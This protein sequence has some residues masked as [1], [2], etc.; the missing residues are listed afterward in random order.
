M[1]GKI[2]A[3]PGE[4][5]RNSAE[6]IIARA[7]EL[8]PGVFGER[9]LRMYGDLFV[10]GSVLTPERLAFIQPEYGRFFPRSDIH[11]LIY[12]KE[13][14]D[15]PH[16]QTAH[17]VD[18]FLGPS[19]GGKDSILDIVKENHP[20]VRIRTTTTRPPRRDASQD[21]I[22]EARYE[23][24]TAEEFVELERGGGFSEVLSPD[25]QGK[26]RYGTSIQ[27]VERALNRDLHLVIWRGDILG[28]P[29]FRS[30]M[31]N[32]HSEIDFLSVF[33]LPKMPIAELW[34]RMTRKRGVEQATAW[35]FP[36]GLL[37]IH[38]A[39]QI[40]DCLVLNPS[41]PSGEPREAAAATLALFRRQ[42]NGL[43]LGSS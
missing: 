3:H 11:P 30:W 6:T 16:T 39:A 34:Q 7:G 13:G 1:R 36:K 18:A 43:V 8:Y 15:F 9:E 2:E 38:S 21:E 42:S 29:Y 31:Q 14:I 26:Y 33:V 20:Y 40:V 27:A 10:E 37:E 23:F 5:S 32:Y 41:D 25:M 24:V 17:T 4:L 28:L 35:R 12:I 22:L 19:A